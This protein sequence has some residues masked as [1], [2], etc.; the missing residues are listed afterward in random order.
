MKGETMEFLMMPRG[1]CDLLPP[2]TGLQLFPLP[3][4]PET[5]LH[6][7]PYH[8]PSH[9]LRHYMDV[10]SLATPLYFSEEPL[11]SSVW[12]FCIWEVCFQMSVKWSKRV[13]C[14]HPAAAEAEK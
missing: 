4:L 13:I 2:L 5:H 3:L 1:S 11:S 10:V 8:G 9:R 6:T 14:P 12:V 7:V